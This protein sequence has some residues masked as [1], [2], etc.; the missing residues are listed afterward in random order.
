MNACIKRE[1][2]FGN[3]TST[4]T[5]S[6]HNNSTQ[7]RDYTIF[8]KERYLERTFSNAHGGAYMRP[9]AAVEGSGFMKF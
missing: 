1:Q 3:K 5:L 7:P 8:Q 4:G 6:R 9:F 2:V